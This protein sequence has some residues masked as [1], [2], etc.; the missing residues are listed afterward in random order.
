[1]RLNLT[2]DMALQKVNPLGS[3]ISNRI[4]KNMRIAGSGIYTY[5]RSELSLYGLDPIPEEYKNK[6]F[7]NIYRP[8]EVLIDNRDMFARIP[9]ITGSHVVVDTSNAKQLA[10]GVTGDTVQYE[11]D[12]NDGEVYL[13][14]TGTIIT[15]DG[16]RAYEELGQLSCGYVPTAKWETGIHKGKDYQAVL[17]GFE[18]VNHLLICKVARGGPQCM[19]MDSLD[20]ASPLEKFIIINGGN[21]MGLLD[22][23][24]GKSRKISGDAR[25]VVPILLQSIGA[26]AD[27]K[28]QVP[29]IRELTK[30]LT[31]DDAAVFQDYLN[32]LEAASGEDLTTMVSAAGIV[33][34]FFCTKLAGDSNGEPAPDAPPPAPSKGTNEE[35]DKGKDEPGDSKEC[36]K[37]HHDPCTCEKDKSAGDKGK[38]EPGNGKDD[39]NKSAGDEEYFRTMIREELDA[40]FKAHQPVQQQTAGDQTVVINGETQKTSTAALMKSIYGGEA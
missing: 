27:P 20:G 21:K 40:Y 35:V 12:K 32:E 13:Y 15:G 11:E 23:L 22:R 26:G 19:F 6:Q 36:P 25:A 16:V 8:P 7:F 1:M 3:N 30:K 4:I 33:E 34:N 38:D 5:H 9:I 37:C 18:D 24:R 14:A 2:G 29:K 31:G 17:T 10:V 39:Q 28:V